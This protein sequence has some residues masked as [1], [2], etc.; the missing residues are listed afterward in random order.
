MFDKNKKKQQVRQKLAIIICFNVQ[1]RAP[2]LP[3]K[4]SYI[5]SGNKK[6]DY[7]F[8]KCPQGALPAPP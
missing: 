2:S 8:P 6:I 4:R 5:I 7:K 1:A 3:Q